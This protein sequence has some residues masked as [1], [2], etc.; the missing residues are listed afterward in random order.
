MNK[1]LRLSKNF[2]QHFSQRWAELRI[3]YIVRLLQAAPLLFTANDCVG[4]ILCPPSD[5]WCL[6]KAA[7]KAGIS[8]LSRL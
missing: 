7:G 2:W 3:H 4:F 6:T 1:L 8:N 5:Y